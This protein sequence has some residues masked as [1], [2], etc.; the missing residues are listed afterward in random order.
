[1][2]IYIYNILQQKLSC[3]RSVCAA[4]DKHAR[5][6]RYVSERR[7]PKQ[8]FCV[9]AASNDPFWAILF[10]VLAISLKNSHA[11]LLHDGAQNAR[12]GPCRLPEDQGTPPCPFHRDLKPISCL[13]V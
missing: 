9:F 11:V 10:R 7:A 1:M 12:R 8:W 5:E 2:G 3:V 6:M 13:T 4:T